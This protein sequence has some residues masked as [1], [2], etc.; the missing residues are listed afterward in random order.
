MTNT[1]IP[2]EASASASLSQDSTGVSYEQSF[3]PGR[4]EISS[5]ECKS[6]QS[7][8]S[9]HYLQI[10]FLQSGFAI[11]AVQEAK[12][13]KKP[14][15]TLYFLCR[16]DTAERIVM[17]WEM[18]AEEN[19]IAHA[20][21]EGNSLH[22]IDCNL[23]SWQIPFNQIP[24]L[25]DIRINDLADFELDEDGS[26]LY[27]KAAD[28]HLDMEALRSVVDSTL[29]EQIKARTLIHDKKFGQAI[30]K[31]RKEF[32]LTQKDIPS[33]SDRQVRRIEKGDRPRSKTLQHLAEAHGLTLS[34]YL[35]KLAE[36]MEDVKEPAV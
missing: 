11:F 3:I 26:Y 22:V 25:S 1:C 23:R 29:R 14:F 24:A 12:D 4:S 17:A 21:V 32:S 30:A 18:G 10:L 20:Y 7:P 5:L 8:S 27:W 35:E 33:V 31:V 9:K 13:S 15:N 36:A 19:L 34:D 2:T 6:I 16:P 28:V